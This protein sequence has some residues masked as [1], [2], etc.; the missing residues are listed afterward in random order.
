MSHEIISTAY[1]TNP[2]DQWYQHYSL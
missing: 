2:F 1:Y